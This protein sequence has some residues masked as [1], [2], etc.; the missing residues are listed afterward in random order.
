[1]YKNLICKC[2]Q[3]QLPRGQHSYLVCIL[4]DGWT[5]LLL[6]ALHL[7]VCCLI[8]LEKAVPEKNL[9]RHPFLSECSGAAG[10]LEVKMLIGALVVLCYFLLEII[11]AHK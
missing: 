3:D 1:M 4:G 5:V 8:G 11:Q 2:K 7:C 10:G 6:P 9:D